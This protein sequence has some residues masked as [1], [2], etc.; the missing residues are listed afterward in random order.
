MMLAA[1]EE[2]SAGENGHHDVASAHHAGPQAPKA[3]FWAAGLAE[4]N[5]RPME[6]TD[7]VCGNEVLAYAP[8]S[9]GVS[10]VPAYTL[11][12]VFKGAGLGTQWD[13]HNCRSAFVGT[14]QR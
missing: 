10:A 2:P 9:R 5:T 6:P 1:F 12:N 7:H 8:L 14:F 13:D 11:S 3:C 4:M